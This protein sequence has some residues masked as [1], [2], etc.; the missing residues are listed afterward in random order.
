MKHLTGIFDHLNP[1]DFG[2][3]TSALDE[4]RPPRKFQTFVDNS[5]NALRVAFA[6]SDGNLNPVAVLASSTVQ[7][8][9]GPN[10]DESLADYIVRLANEARI[11]GA[12]WVF[13]STRTEG[14]LVEVEYDGTTPLNGINNIDD[15]T[16]VQEQGLD[17]EMVYYYAVQVTN[18]EVTR[19]QGLLPITASNS[20]GEIRE[21]APEQPSLFDAILMGMSSS[22]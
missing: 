3:E 19:R 2:H 16:A 7:R 22:S 14:A 12:H 5:L 9:F 17:E 4:T 15:M 1:D 18:D 10:D 21:G 13:I 6:A 20:L 11:I 8:M